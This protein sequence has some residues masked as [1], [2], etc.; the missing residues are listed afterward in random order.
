MSN[1]LAA[2]KVERRT[3]AIAIFRDHTLRYAE[4]LSLSSNPKIAAASAIDFLLRTIHRFD[5]RK[6]AFEDAHT[7]EEARSAELLQQVEAALGSVG[8]G[9]MRVK[10][11]TLFTSYSVEPLSSRRE[12]H[13]I[14]G[15]FWPQLNTGDFPGAVLD[16]AA[17]GL[18]ADTEDRLG[19]EAT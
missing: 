10:K 9:T 15:E 8:F 3:V 4:A 12:L 19:G 2:V 18:Y 6:I 16:A 1:S 17:L 11:Q 14:V 7:A 5:I 13:L